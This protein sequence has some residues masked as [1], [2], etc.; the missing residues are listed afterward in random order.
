MLKKINSYFD[1]RESIICKKG[2]TFETILGIIF[3]LIAI[4]FAFENNYLGMSIFLTLALGTISIGIAFY[5]VGIGLDSDKKMQSIST[6]DFY[7]LSYTFWDRAPCLYNE[8]R[9][10]VRDTCSWQLSNLFRHGKKLKRW[11]DPDVQE[12]LIKEFKTFL[13]R[14]RPLPCQKY[15]VEVKNYMG[16]CEIAINFKTKNDQ[17]KNELIEELGNWIGKKEE[18]ESNQEFLQRK[19]KEFSGK[20]DNDLF[21]IV[22]ET[23]KEIKKEVNR[24]T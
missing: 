20:K 22:K 4:K 24:R 23:D 3:F 2:G 15:W 6:A 9:S 1:K 10:E 11:A 7:K 8:Q 18:K 17:I 21:E 19:S 14:L 12:D 13:T 16:I 5:S